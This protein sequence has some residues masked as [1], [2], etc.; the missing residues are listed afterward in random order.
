MST[1]EK[2]VAE[3]GVQGA[4]FAPIGTDGY[5]TPVKLK[6]TVNITLS[7]NV[8]RAERYAD[9]RLIISI[10]NEPFMD[11]SMGTTA[12]DIE[13]EKMAGISMEVAGGVAT[14]GMVKYLRGALYF[15]HIE[16]VEDGTSKL[17]KTWVYNVEVG[18]GETNLSTKTAS[19]TFADY[20]YPIRSMGDTLMANDGE[21]E[22]I[23][24]NGMKRNVFMF[25]AWPDDAGYATFG[26]AV[27]VPKALPAP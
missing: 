21:T 23:D 19:I 16:I 15:E 5:D 1:R 22:Y 26:D 12:H 20:V 11:G 17:V 7:P 3:I 6:Y 27:P 9:N 14:L 13:L 2:V 8:E 4:K 24:Q 25:N 10:P 18:K